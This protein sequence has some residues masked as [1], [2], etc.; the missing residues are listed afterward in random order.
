M[1]K[2]V[3][4]SETNFSSTF[5][6]KHY[7]FN[8]YNQ[9]KKLKYFAFLFYILSSKYVYFTLRKHKTTELTIGFKMKK[10]SFLSSTSHI[11]SAE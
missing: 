1:L 2:K 8:M 3:K 11:S 6:P 7:H 9:H 10:F 5:N 4:T